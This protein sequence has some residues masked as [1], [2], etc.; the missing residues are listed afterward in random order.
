MNEIPTNLNLHE[1]CKDRTE[2]LYSHCLNWC[3]PQKNLNL[4]GIVKT[5]PKRSIPTASAGAAHTGNLG[6]NE[7]PCL[8]ICSVGVKGHW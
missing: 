7:H 2:G 1:N 4:H 3:C 6:D 5:E 8:S